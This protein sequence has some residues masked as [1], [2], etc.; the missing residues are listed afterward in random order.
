MSTVK[1]AVNQARERL[2][3]AAAQVDE[4]RVELGEATLELTY[5][6]EVEDAL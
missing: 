6:L 2:L 5:W 1:D 4:A 3:R